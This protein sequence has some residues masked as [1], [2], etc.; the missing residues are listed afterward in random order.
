M[1]RPRPSATISLTAALVTMAVALTVG[2]QFLV[3][4][5]FG[6]LV[7]GFTALHWLAI[8]LGSLFFVVII[9]A[10]ILQAVWLVR[11][12]RTNQRQ[13]NFI[14]AAT[15]ELNTPLASLRL[16][17]DTLRKPGLD[18]ET[19]REFVE[20][21][22]DDLDRLQ[23]TIDRVL[24]AART[25]ERHRPREQ[26]DLTGL[27]GECVDEARQRHGLG[28]ER[29]RLQAPSGAR[30]RGDIEQ[31]RLAFRNLLENAVRYGGQRPE[32]DVRL[33][34]ASGR[35][36]EVEVED[37]GQGIPRS[38]LHRV[39]QRFQRLSIEGVGARGLG[40]G[41]YI[42]RNVVRAH[43]GRVRAESDGLG[44]GSRFVVR[45]PGSVS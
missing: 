2:W 1:R 5:G 40:L 14:D 4:R 37:R 43:G 23:H 8:V 35:R 45:L 34:P 39:F 15:H 31:L 3:L 27:L 6:A 38:A 9:T 17:L 18:D 10:S 20:V 41:L 33:R 25:V 28:P 29:I 36:L 44:T 11:E 26:V 24:D 42:V 12:I 21:M 32:V 19:R 16:Y 7:E 30:V 13:Q 22:S